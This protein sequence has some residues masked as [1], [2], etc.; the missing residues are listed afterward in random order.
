MYNKATT[1]SSSD[2]PIY[3]G[4]IPANN[5]VGAGFIQ[6]IIIGVGMSAGISYRVTGAIA[7]NDTTALT[8]NTIL[9]NVAYS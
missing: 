7:D 9:V 5:S 1:P 6:P 8:A 4:V 2:T 3:R